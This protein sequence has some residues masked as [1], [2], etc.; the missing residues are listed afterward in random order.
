MQIAVPALRPFRH[1]TA[2]PAFPITIGT[3]PK[4]SGVFREPVG[5]AGSRREPVE[6]LEVGLETLRGPL[7]TLASPGEAAGSGRNTQ[8][9][10]ARG[11]DRGEDARRAFGVGVDRLER[12]CARLNGY[13]G[14][15]PSS[16]TSNPT[17]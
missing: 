9:R 8:G 1:R 10:A 2:T 16:T 13:L 6:T 15:K 4:G 17:P 7:E 11:T 5:N 3:P 12:P 14:A